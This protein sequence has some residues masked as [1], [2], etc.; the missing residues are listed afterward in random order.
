MIG[1]QQQANAERQDHEAERH[2]VEFLN[3]GDE[4]GQQEDAC[5]RRLLPA[6]RCKI[7]EQRAAGHGDCKN[8]GRYSNSVSVEQPVGQRR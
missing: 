7:G 6:Q 5:H 3:G 1:G 2:G 8:D 4:S